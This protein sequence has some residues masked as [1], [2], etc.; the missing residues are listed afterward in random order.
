LSATL[1]KDRALEVAFEDE[2]LLVV[3]KPAGMLSVPGKAEEE[4][5]VYR[6]VRTM[7][8]EATGPL[9]VH[10][11]DM[12]T[13]GLLLVAKTK[14]VHRLLQEQFARRTVKKRYVALLAGL[15]EEGRETGRIELPLCPDPL[16]RPRQMVS[17]E[18]G[19]PAI[20]EYRVLERAN[21]CTRILF[22]PLTGRTHQL[23]VHAAHPA[24][25]GHPIVGDELYGQK[26]ERLCLHA[27]YLEFRHPISGDTICLQEEAA[28]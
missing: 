20:T 21:G 2:W 14:E 11:L 12:A 23:R 22:Y 3:N 1:H 17:I 6:R 9:V 24:G 13:S 4:D 5:S 8:P 26:A 27:E 19:K 18:H 25:L 7:Y 16:D 28:F 15:V 10:R